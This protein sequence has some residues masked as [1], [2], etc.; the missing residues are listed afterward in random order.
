LSGRI[1]G[2]FVGLGEIHHALF[3]I[4]EGHVFQGGLLGGLLDEKVFGFEYAH[5]EIARPI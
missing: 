2:A 4:G 1:F 3:E 5:S